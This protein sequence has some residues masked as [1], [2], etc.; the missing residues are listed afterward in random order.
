MDVPL[1]AA[2]V[3]P[4]VRAQGHPA[5]RRHV[6]P[7]TVII[8]SLGDYS[9]TCRG[10]VTDSPLCAGHHAETQAESR[11]GGVGWPLRGCTGAQGRVSGG[12]PGL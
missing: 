8:P 12:G 10:A 3:S 1:P 6:G 5:V 7:F 9:G 4:P 11:G 2:S